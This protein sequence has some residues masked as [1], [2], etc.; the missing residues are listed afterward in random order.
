MSGKVYDGEILGAEEKAGNEETVRRGFWQKIRK[1][2]GKIP[3]IDEVVAGYFCA[4]DRSTPVRVRTAIFGA[5]AYF[6]LPIDVIPDFILGTGFTDDIAVLWATLTTVRSHIL[7]RHREAA[8]AALEREQDR[9]GPN[10][11][12][13]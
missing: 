11:R 13:I 1:A 12:P 7:P 8:R 4:I 2:A 5:L 3:F 6:I 10:S 9:M